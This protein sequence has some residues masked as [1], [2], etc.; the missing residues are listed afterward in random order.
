MFLPINLQVVDAALQTFLSNAHTIAA[1]ESSGGASMR[2]KDTY[3]TLCHG[4]ENSLR[5]FAN[6]IS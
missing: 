3:K 1:H 4:P 6:R 2:Q 5:G